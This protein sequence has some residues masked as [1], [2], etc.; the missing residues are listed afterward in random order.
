M[1]EISVN[2]SA[3]DAEQLANFG[4]GLVLLIQR[5][6]K[7]AKIRNGTPEGLAPACSRHRA[8]ATH[9]YAERAESTL[10]MGHSL[11]SG[12]PMLTLPA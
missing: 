12:R 9:D 7:P 1:G 6:L 10:R 8:T 4:N 2:G 3:T 11:H 5:L